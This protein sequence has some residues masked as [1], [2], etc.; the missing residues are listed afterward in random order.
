M[1]YH[2]KVTAS[3]VA[4]TPLHVVP[5]NALQPWLIQED[6]ASLLYLI[7]YIYTVELKRLHIPC[8]ICT[9]KNHMGSTDVKNARRS[10][11]LI[12]ALQQSLSLDRPPLLQI[13]RKWYLFM[14]TAKCISLGPEYYNRKVIWF[15]LPLADF[16]STL[17]SY[18]STHRTYA[19][20]NT[21]VNKCLF[22]AGC[23]GTDVAEASPLI[24]LLLGL[25]VRVCQDWVCLLLMPNLSMFLRSGVSPGQFTLRASHLVSSSGVAS[26]SY[27]KPFCLCH[28]IQPEQKRLHLCPSR[29]S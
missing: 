22:W 3:G 13:L 5:N 16:I 9:Q 1:L 12:F 10:S 23:H 15:S 7:T 14:E 28:V 2:E 29:L 24:A 11:C 18:G 20:F 21:K 26:R 25:L 8:K 19:F 6:T 17:Y 4:L 27:F